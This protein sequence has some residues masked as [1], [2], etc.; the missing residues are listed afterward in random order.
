M[1]VTRKPTPRYYLNGVDDQ[2]SRA[3][4]ETPVTIPQFLLLSPIFT[5][6]GDGEERIVTRETFNRIY[7]AESLKEESPY[8]TH[9]SFLVNEIFNV[10]GQVMIKSIKTPGSKKATIN[11]YV[12]L[13]T[14]V[15]GGLEI[16]TI[17]N[18]LRWYSVQNVDWINDNIS[19]L[20]D[21]PGNYNEFPEIV[22]YFR[23][24][25][26]EDDDGAIATSPT[27]LFRVMSLDISSVGTHGNEYG[28]RLSVP[29]GNNARSSVLTRLSKRIKSRVFNLELVKYDSVSGQTLIVPNK[30]GDPTTE[31]T[32]MENVYH[33]DTDQ[34]L[35]IGKVLAENWITG[36]TQDTEFNPIGRVDVSYS[37][38][39][40][41]QEGIWADGYRN[42]AET[43]LE[44]DDD[45]SVNQ[46]D[47][48][49]GFNLLGQTVP[50]VF[51][52]PSDYR[53]GSLHWYWGAT[54]LFSQGI[55]AG[56]E[57][58]VVSEINQVTG[59]PLTVLDRDIRRISL[60]E[61]QVYGYLLSVTDSSSKYTDQARYP[62]RDFVDSGF[63]YMNKDLIAAMGGLRKD[64]NTYISTF[65]L[66]PEPPV[67]TS[68]NGPAPTSLAPPTFTYS[69][70]L[71]N[72]FLRVNWIDPN[73][74][75][76][77]VYSVGAVQ[78]DYTVTKDSNGNYTAL[79]S[80]GGNLG[81][82]PV[83]NGFITAYVDPTTGNL[84]I[85]NIISVDL[86]STTVTAYHEFGAFPNQIV[87][88]DAV[89]LFPQIQV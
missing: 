2:T 42:Y 51:T 39:N 11:L 26:T 22:N 55:Q 16:N 33:P 12:E 86:D 43:T 48:V 8:F 4:E 75:K 58:P 56:L 35:S 63:S 57:E 59:L 54:M 67:P 60:Y 89:Y 31:V 6:Q 64:I 49:T 81:N 65:A 52:V 18:Q 23:D 73:A 9:Q 46:I 78:V 3:V 53:F 29:T 74:E 77:Y 32:F 83:N 68:S 7:G 61:N 85:E 72:V 79:D 69:N 66:L 41:I 34:A 82:D 76:M 13:C 80:N 70:G 15:T 87:S 17:T 84:T 50:S 44:A 40:L 20:S 19:S 38:Y 30:F 71:G 37:N 28:I 36:E 62:F 21:S 45:E 47:L 1:A 14:T 25:D 24:A 10:G 27:T 88:N 5:R